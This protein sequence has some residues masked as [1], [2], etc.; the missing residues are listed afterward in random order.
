MLTVCFCNQLLQ[1]LQ[2]TLVVAT[3]QD[4]LVAF[5]QFG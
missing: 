5:Q 1:P 4:V 3:Q 2:L